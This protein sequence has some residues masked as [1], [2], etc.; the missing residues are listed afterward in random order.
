MIANVARRTRVKICGITTA[1]D[2]ETAAALGADV[3]GVVFAPSKRRVDVTR[4]REIAAALPPMVVLCGVFLDAPL[5]EM[6]R[7]ADETRL[8]LIQLHGV[9]A[10]ELLAALGRRVIKRIHVAP[11]STRQSLETEAER[12]AGAAAILLDPGAGDGQ[13]F[14]WSIVAAPPTGSTSGVSEPS[15]P[16]HS[17]RR[18]LILSGGLSPSNVARAV[19]IVRPMAVDVSSGVEA[20]PG[21]KDAAKMRD[22]L[23]AVREADANSIT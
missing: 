18:R 19:D 21:V 16:L 9:E 3:I 13:P 11:G 8:D 4:A 14:D 15:G 20:S 10:P 22:F 1:R 7:I 5:A 12:Y 6:R 2:A 23:A 17:L